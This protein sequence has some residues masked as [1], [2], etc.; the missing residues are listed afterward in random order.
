MLKV[1]VPGGLGGV[2]RHIVDALLE[3]GLYEVIILTRQ[4]DKTDLSSKKNVTVKVVDYN[5]HSDLVEALAGVHT[6]LCTIFMSGTGVN[7]PN[8][9]AQKNL[10]KAAAE[11]GAK[12]YAP[13]EYGCLKGDQP[14]KTAVIDELAK[15]PSLESTLY[16]IGLFMDYFAG[17]RNTTYLKHLVV[18]VD[19]DKG[20]ALSV[21]GTGNE[22]VVFSKVEDVAKFVAASL[23]LD[24]WPEVSGI[25]GELTNYN[26][27]I[28]TLEK[29]QGRKYKV[30]YKT[31]EELKVDPAPLSHLGQFI[32]KS[33]FDTPDNLNKL[34]PSIKAV[35]LEEYL[36]SI[37]SK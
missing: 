7:G 5:S 13:S 25:R 18:V 16:M 37:W 31:L 28:E 11:V 20:E 26:T 12:R 22:P 10:I 6:V 35:G 9:T 1:A 2:G 27:V 21:P 23:S 33:K 29:I 4:P 36:K 34:I 8:V 24:K 17:S 14:E 19:P 30:G 32:A 15:Y 3:T